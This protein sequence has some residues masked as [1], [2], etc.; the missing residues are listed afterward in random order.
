MTQG[1]EINNTRKLKRVI[2]KEELMALTGNVNEAIVL[3]QLIKWSKKDCCLT[4]SQSCWIRKTSAEMLDEI[5]FAVSR[6][7]VDRAFKSL[8]DKKIVN[9]RKSPHDKFDHAW[10][11]QINLIFIKSELLNMGYQ[12]EVKDD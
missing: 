9:R 12:G 6:K 10:Q 4:E 3:D 8:V 1:I 11:Y 7:T 2:V 5:M